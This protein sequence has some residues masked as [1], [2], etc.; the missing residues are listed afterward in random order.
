[1][2][3]LFL[4]LVTA[5]ALTSYSGIQLGVNIT[6][7]VGWSTCA[8]VR[9]DATGLS[10]PALF[11]AC[12]ADDWILA[13]YFNGQTNY[14]TLAQ[15]STSFLSALNTLTPTDD[16]GAS[17]YRSAT[18]GFG[19]VAIGGSVMMAP[20][21]V[22]SPG[23][24]TR[25][26]RELSSD[27]IDVGGR[28]AGQVGLGPGVN[29]N[30]RMVILF[31]PCKGQADGTSCT[32]HSLCTTGDQCINQAC[33][34]TVVPPP[35]FGDCRD[36][37]VCD[38]LT[39]VYTAED[40]DYGLS[41]NDS[42]ECTEDDFCDGYGT[43]MG[44][45]AVVCPVPTFPCEQDGVCQPATGVCT[46]ALK[47]AGEPCL[48]DL[49]C[50]INERCDALGGCTNVTQRSCF[51]G[52][53]CRDEGI[54]NEIGQT[55]DF[56]ISADDTF[57]TLPDAVC[58]G[59]ASCQA[60]VCT[61]TGAGAVICP[62]PNQCQVSSECNA[63]VCVVVNKPNNVTC[64]DADP[65]TLDDRCFSGVCLGTA[66]T[67]TA[68]SQCHDVGTCSGG[69]CSN[70]FKANTEDC[71]DFDPCT[72]P[73]KCDGAGSCIPGPAATCPFIDQCFD[74][75]VC[76]TVLGCDYSALSNIP[77]D[78]SDHCTLDTMCDLGECGGGDLNYYDDTC[79]P[80]T[81][82]DS[83]STLSAFLFR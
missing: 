41:C 9:Y 77:C 61:A 46:Y 45:S 20:C 44:G 42:N 80:T 75:P 63:G 47:A 55:C 6:S 70:P 8:D 15:T 7:V 67:C 22:N 36:E 27:A 18:D 53:S 54:C 1:M 38:P 51:A 69:T 76:D 74:V 43:C 23:V 25:I 14:A 81:P 59:N 21:D 30:A 37:P 32:D 52:I 71:T 65:C 17:W 16:N 33:V 39:G 49:Y 10:L 60:G 62:A 26:C 35:D 24:Q 13:C 40:L 3:R 2:L 12:P 19:F 4:L 78:D 29:G 83:A 31:N 58:V 57:C 34:G 79:F 48:D 68:L 66:V 28:C 64:D 11:T 50:T 5:A 72:G 73:D 56:P 82:I